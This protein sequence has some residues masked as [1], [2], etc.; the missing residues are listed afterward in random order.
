MERE[1]PRGCTAREDLARVRG[2]AH[3]PQRKDQS[4]L[5][6]LPRAQGLVLRIRW[7]RVGRRRCWQVLVEERRGGGKLAL[8]GQRAPKQHAER[9][10][11]LHAQQPPLLLR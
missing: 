2:R 7:R 9:V 1:Q 8:G 3:A 6:A 10:G 5:D 11:R 4:A